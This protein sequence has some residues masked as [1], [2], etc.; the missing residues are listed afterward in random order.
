M[1][2]N[3]YDISIIIPYYKKSNIVELIL[4]NLDSQAN[5]SNLSTE[6]LVVDSSTDSDKLK[7]KYNKIKVS[8]HHTI[9]NLSAKRNHGINLSTGKVIVCIDDDCV[10]SDFFLKEHFVNNINSEKKEIFSG[11]E[12]IKPLIKKP[13]NFYKYRMNNISISDMK[14][15]KSNKGMIFRARAMNFS[16]HSKYK[17]ILPTFLEEINGYGWEDV[18][19]FKDSLEAGFKISLCDALIEHH[20]EETPKSYF[21]K[22]ECFGYYSYMAIVKINTLN[23]NNFKLNILNLLYRFILPIFFPLTLIIYI[24]FYNL[25]CLLSYYLNINSYQLHRIV[26]F[27]AILKGSSNS[28][29]RSSRFSYN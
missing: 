14:S 23:L 28:H 11:S 7:I 9:N 20:I 3:N 21:K 16:F 13:K 27:L 17:S 18:I 25:N 24:I 22:M 15:N 10:P 6:V 19:F 26:Y 5:I 1:T 2:E 12:I 29:K 4:N 8:I